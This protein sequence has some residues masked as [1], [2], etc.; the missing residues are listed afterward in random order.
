MF[1]IWTVLGSGLAGLNTAAGFA[2]SLLTIRDHFKN[3]S[4]ELLSTLRK[5]SDEAY[6][7]YCSYREYR[8]DELGLP[9][10]EAILGYWERCLRRN[11]FPCADDMAA[12][13]IASREEA[14]AILL[15]LMGQ[16]MTVPEFSAWMHDI[17]HQHRLDEISKALTDL[18]KLR[19]E[20]AAIRDQLND[21]DICGIAA[22]ISPGSVHEAKCLCSPA[23]VKNFFTVDNSFHT[24][25]QVIS[26][27]EDVPRREAEEAV[28]RQLETGAPLIITGNGG[29][30]KTSLMM[31]A[32]VQWASS[33]RLAVWLSLSG[34]E[35][36]TEAAADRFF[37]GLTRL[38]PAG[39]RILLCIDNP[40]EGRDSLT[41][42]GARWPYGEKIQLLM[43]ERENRLTLLADPDQDRLLHWFDGASLVVLQGV[44]QTRPYSLKDYPSLRFPENP[45]RRSAILRKSTSYLV[46]EGVIRGADQ[47]SVIEKILRQ[48]GKP[49]VSLVELIY[50]TLFEL[51]KIAAKPG[52][53]KLD[54]EEWGGLI[55]R[56]FRTDHSDIQLY[57]VI[58]ALKVFNTP[59]PLSLFCKYFSLDPRK[60]GSRLQERF[61]PRHVEPVVYHEGSKTLQP[62][63]DVIAEL[64]FLFNKGKVFINTLM[65]DLIDV[66]EEPEIEALLASIVNK[67][68]IRRGTKPP[69]GEIHYWSCLERIYL[70]I[71]E[72][73]L[74]LSPA[75]RRYLCLGILWAR[76]QRKPYGHSPTVK[77]ILD[78]I[79]PEIETDLLAAKLY[80]EWGIWAAQEKNAS[81]AEEKFLAV[82]D[83]NPRQ[84]PAR[85]E[86]GRL[87]SRQKGREKD[88]EEF[89]LQVIKLSPRDIQSRTE[90]GRLL[91]KQK[92]R[93]KDAEEFLLEAIK[94]DP[95]HIHSRTELGRLLSKQKGREKDAEE[96][97]LEAIK[98]DPKHI[99]S[100]T[101]LGR[102]LSKQ[103]GRE[104]DA[105]K[106]LLEAIEI[107]PTQLHA[108]T[109][110]AKLY[111]RLNR[112]EDARRL[113]QEICGIEPDNRFG[114]EGLARLEHL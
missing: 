13:Q 68:D 61:V 27:G 78:G 14:E 80:T 97:L 83:H 42:L 18:P 63:H 91:S 93:E 66:M 99:Q 49:A 114:R 59:T 1:T 38:T 70:R 81:L 105:E 10:R 75:G 8:R 73:T 21:R 35:F 113:Y 84:L 36:I 37:A 19:E 26:A 43:A 103:K 48:Y 5:K 60:L 86:L 50:R 57:G 54:W 69:I 62:K 40:F 6:A 92:G 76:R 102:L 46:E 33:G 45:E 88:A 65:E 85:T 16:W 112:P 98:I 109:V 108:R 12:L 24:M 71:Q 64:F 20:A 15:F 101:E 34:R 41:S 28:L 22:L 55:R 25:L 110:L 111:E 89:L 31:R 53:I 104:K 32:A 44:N 106:F 67:R 74:R 7:Q 58:A 23:A 90:L 77:D 107:N 2:G 95:N 17:L 30:G 51:K 87:L 52:S 82:I 4:Q 96:F 94:I 47:A 39:R 9:D 100:R 56:E 29:Q 79:A 3:P 11:V 72:G